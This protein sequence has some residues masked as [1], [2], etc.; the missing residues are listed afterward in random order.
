MENI[1][2]G[3][4]QLDDI[5]KAEHLE[6]VQGF[7]DDNGYQR[8]MK[9]DKIDEKLG[10]YHIFD[11][12]KQMHICG[13]EKYQQLIAFLKKESLVGE[14]FNGSVSIACSGIEASSDPELLKSAKGD[15]IP[16]RENTIIQ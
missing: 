3:N 4:L 2:F 7:L 1:F 15:N 8:E 6:K 16:S 13:Y 10:N 5:V 9:C 14:G 12:P 11:M